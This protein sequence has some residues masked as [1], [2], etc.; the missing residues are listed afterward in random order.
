[1]L[2]VSKAF[3]RSTKVMNIGFLCSL[4]FSYSWRSEET[5]SDVDG[6]AL[7]PDKWSLIFLHR[8]FRCAIFTFS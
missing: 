3:V 7:D 2:T 8:Q 4:R 1:M 5:I 6:P